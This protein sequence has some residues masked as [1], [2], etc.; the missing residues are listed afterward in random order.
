MRIY[1]IPI[2][3]PHQGCPHDCA[4]CNQKKITGKQ[5][6]PTPQ[7][8][9][10]L[11]R[12]SLSTMKRENR[13]AEAAFFGG[14]FTA[15]PKEEQEALLTAAYPFR[16]SGELDGIRVSTRPDAITE[17]GLALLKRHGVTTIEL[18]IQSMDNGVLE[19]SGRGHT[20]ADSMRAAELIRRSGI[21][22][23]VQMMTGL[24]EDTDE[25]SQKT[26]REL[27]AMHPVCA[28]I[29]P[30]LVLRDTEL[31]RRWHSGEYRPQELSEAVELCAELYTM[32]SEAG[33]P[34]IRMGLMASD[35]ICEGGAVAAG[36]CHPAFGELVQSHIL[37]QRMKREGTDRGE[38]VEIRVNPKDISRAVGNRRRNLLELEAHFGKPVRICP[39]EGVPP[40]FSGEKD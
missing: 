13:F 6:A 28:R 18:G 15:I 24:P 12:A 14:S 36:P 38:R 21:G 40:A 23:G 7:E 29:Y 17:E 34:V 33:I 3:V 16:L 26:A 22:L 1:H 10:E 39:D 31:Y 2:F 4:F 32:F 20:A 37:L 9:A 35:E 5:K 30:T 27:I 11:I 25:K 19:A 8:A